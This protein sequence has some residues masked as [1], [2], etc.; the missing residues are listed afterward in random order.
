MK[1]MKRASSIMIPVM[2]FFLLAGCESLGIPNIFGEDEVPEEVKARPSVLAPPVFAKQQTWPRL[3]DVPSKPKDFTQPQNYN[4]SMDELESQR[5]DA[6]AAKGNTFGSGNAAP[7]D[8]PLE[9]PRFS[10]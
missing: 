1:N 10:R 3:G 2:S 4:K 5:R 9:A 7:R 6:E 8:V